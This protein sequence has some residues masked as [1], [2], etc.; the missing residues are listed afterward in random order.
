MK[1]VQKGYLSWDSWE[2][3]Q[4]Y[5]HKAVVAS[6]V[7]KIERVRVVCLLQ[8][9]RLFGT[10]LAQKKFNQIVIQQMYQPG[11]IILVEDY[12]SKDPKDLN[13]TRLSGLNPSKYEFRG[14]DNPEATWEERQQS[15]QDNIKK[16]SENSNRTLFVQMG[17]FHGISDDPSYSPTAAEFLPALQVSFIIFK[18]EANLV[19]TSAVST[20]LITP[21]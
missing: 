12:A 18:F 17:P 21:E 9:H 16:Y 1:S 5:L 6:N 8:S 20:S 15:L 3:I 10:D 19:R 2:D 14:W 13:K 7:D 11:D 4:P